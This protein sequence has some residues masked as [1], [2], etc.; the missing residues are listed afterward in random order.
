LFFVNSL[1]KNKLISTFFS[2]GLIALSLSIFPDIAA[3]DYPGINQR[4][5]SFVIGGQ[6]RIL[7]AGGLETVK[8]DALALLNQHPNDGSVGFDS[9]PSS[10]KTLGA[11]RVEIDNKT[12]SVI[13]YIEQAH[14]FDP[15][16]FGYVKT[17]EKEVNPRILSRE[18]NN[19]LWKLGDG[20]YFFETW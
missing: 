14:I 3:G 17:I 5:S 7:W 13:I 8:G 9:W 2:L 16:Q 4:V 20:I 15:D 6:T 18:E 1:S 10:L 12:Q 11:V 19:R